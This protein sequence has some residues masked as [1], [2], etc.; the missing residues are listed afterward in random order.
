MKLAAR[1][2]FTIESLATTKYKHITLTNADLLLSLFLRDCVR[3]FSAHLT[4]LLLLSSHFLVFLLS[5]LLLL[6]LCLLFCFSDTAVKTG[7]FF[8]CFFFGLKHLIIFIKI[9]TVPYG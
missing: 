3:F 5:F 1:I 2:N 7:I 9:D 8:D 6:L 4:V